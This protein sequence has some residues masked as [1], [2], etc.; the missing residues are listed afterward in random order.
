M[1]Y[2]IIC[3]KILLII[4][5]INYKSG[6]HITIKN[7]KNIKVC[8]C[9]IGK[10]ENRYIREF[11][12]FYKR[13]GVD[14]I[15]LY[16]NNDINDEHFEDVIIDYVDTNFVEIINWRGIERPHF[17]AFNN[18]Y[19]SYNNKYDWLIFYDIDEYIHLT[20]YTNIKDFLNENKFNKCKKIY[21]NWVFHTDNDLVYYKK[22]PLKKRFPEIE[23]D[24]LINKNYMQKVKSIL[25]G[26]ISNF[27]ISN[28]SHTS[29]VITD[30]VDACNGFG[31]NIKLNFEYLM[32]NSD[33]KYFYI[34]HY[35][36]KS[37]E[38]FVKKLNKGSAVNGQDEKFKLFRIFRYFNINKIK[39]NKFLYFLKNVKIKLEN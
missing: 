17:S 25:R 12:K 20:N 30:S 33:T 14:K 9:T 23:R 39:N 4:I 13:L 15:F 11:V 29:H 18:C 24:A 27:L 7:D 35:Y 31:K 16:D 37:T 36:S 10:E 19:L 8:M 26:N 38:E 6:N 22:G 3:V 2:L 21:L 34:D 1:D 32:K 28:H 5:I